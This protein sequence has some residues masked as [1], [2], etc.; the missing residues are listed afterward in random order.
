M[1][2]T[3]AGVVV[4]IDRGCRIQCQCIGDDLLRAD[5]LMCGIIRGKARIDRRVPP[6]SRSYLLDFEHLT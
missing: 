4:V 3:P 2:E 5:V 6:I 1:G